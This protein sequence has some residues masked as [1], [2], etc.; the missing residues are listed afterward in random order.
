MNQP[1]ALVFKRVHGWGASLSSS[2][3]KY[4]EMTGAPFREGYAYKTGN[5]L[6]TV[7]EILHVS[8]PI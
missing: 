1:I 3:N 7:R 8:F 5:I 4:G 2:S 6:G